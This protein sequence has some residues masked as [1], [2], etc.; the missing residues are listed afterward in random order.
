MKVKFLFLILALFILA[1]SFASALT[2]S[3]G[4]AR[5][6]L[7][8]EAGD[9]IEK[10]VLVKNVNN[11]SININISVS[12]DLADYVDLDKESFV[13]QPGEEKKAYFTIEAKKPGQYETKINVQFSPLETGNGV[14][15]S[16]T[17][18]LNVYG[19]GEMPE[20][21]EESSDGNITDNGIGII[22][23]LIGEKKLNPAIIILPIT[24]VV[25]LGLFLFILIKKRNRKAKTILKLKQKKRADRSS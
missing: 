14:G 2:G 17:V 18:I 22:G 23:S 20:E 13:L 3:I 24:T 12:G 11:E 8:A 5:M 15:L 7:K 16:S 4:N 1:S 10:Y 9:V 21:E 25:L 6:I 19:K